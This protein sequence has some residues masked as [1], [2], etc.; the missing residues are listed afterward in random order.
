MHN[1]EN[2]ASKI[3]NT[4]PSSSFSSSLSTLKII[5]KGKKDTLINNQIPAS[6]NS[7]SNSQIDYTLNTTITTTGNNINNNHKSYTDDVD[8]LNQ[9]T[10]R[11]ESN[12]A[13][14]ATNV[15]K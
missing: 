2:D 7:H 11:Q 14:N 8:K 5:S 4:T 3:H 10:I 13:N 15:N 1:K 12:N 9:G 6:I